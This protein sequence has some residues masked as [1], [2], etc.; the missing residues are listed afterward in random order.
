MHQYSLYLEY[1]Y[2]DAFYNEPPMAVS[3]IIVL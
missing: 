1:M 2:T 3:A